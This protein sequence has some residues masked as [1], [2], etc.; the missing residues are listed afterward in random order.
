MTSQNGVRGHRF[1]IK[2]QRFI[3][4]RKQTHASV[5]LDILF[6][7]L[8]NPHSPL[9]CSFVSLLQTSFREAR[10]VHQHTPTDV[11]V[12]GSSFLL[13]FLY[14]FTLRVQVF[15][16]GQKGEFRRTEKKAFYVSRNGKS[17]SHRGG[18]PVQGPWTIYLYWGFPL[19]GEE[20]FYRQRL[21]SA[22]L[23]SI[24][25]SSRLAALPS[26]QTGTMQPFVWAGNLQHRQTISTTLATPPPF[27]AFSEMSQIKREREPQILL[28]VFP[29]QLYNLKKTN[30]PHTH[31]STA[32]LTSP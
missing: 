17:Q 16:S 8:F 23:F 11:G 29:P 21:L 32:C 31:D 22:Q 19:G 15:C 6:P 2:R 13:E 14:N 18:V 4:N 1:L 28:T 30:F 24:T 12:P 26:K 5:L 9:V 27:L 7:H 3:E 10:N 25:L 20:A